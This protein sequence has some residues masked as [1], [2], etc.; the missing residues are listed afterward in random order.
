MEAFICAHCSKEL[1][2]AY[3]AKINC[4]AAGSGNNCSHRSPCLTAYLSSQGQLDPL[5][6]K[7]KM[8]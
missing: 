2:P 1:C 4:V 3:V 7:Q 5:P 8:P 6:V